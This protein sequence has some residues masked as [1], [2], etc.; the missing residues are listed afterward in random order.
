MTVNDWVLILS[1]G[2]VGDWRMGGLRRHMV[3]GG[4]RGSQG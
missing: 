4:P 3:Y 2:V 1:K